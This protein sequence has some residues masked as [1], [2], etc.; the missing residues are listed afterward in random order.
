MIETG[1][2]VVWA[3]IDTRV[4]YAPA[5]ELDRDGPFIVRY[6]EMD[7]LEAVYRLQDPKDGFDFYVSCGYNAGSILKKHEQAGVV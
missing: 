3:S 6:I 7:G 2:L 4:V 5:G 1:D